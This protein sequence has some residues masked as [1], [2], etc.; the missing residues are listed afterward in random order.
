MQIAVNGLTTTTSPLQF[1]PFLDKI[2]TRMCFFSNT[3]FASQSL[4]FAA[5]HRVAPTKYISLNNLMISISSVICKIQNHHETAFP[6]YQS[7]SSRSG[8]QGSIIQYMII[9]RT[10]KPSLNVVL[11]INEATLIPQRNE[12]ECNC[13]SVQTLGK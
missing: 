4:K 1:C 3:F 12:S 5:R 8:V 13:S 10:N 9:N 6:G 11:N 7:C 2:P